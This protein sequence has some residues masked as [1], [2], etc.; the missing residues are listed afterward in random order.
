MTLLTICQQVAREVGVSVPTTI[1]SNN[2]P[3]AKKLL[4]CAQTEGRMLAKGIVYNAVGQ[5]K[6][7]H[8]WTAIRKEYT[9]NTANG[10]MA[11]NMPSDFERFVVDTWWN[12]TQTRRLT[13]ASA[14]RWQNL[15]SGLASS[16]GINQEF[17]KRGAQVLIY[18]TPTAT[19]TLVYEYVS[20]QWCESSGGTD[21]SSWAADSDVLLLDEDLFIAG[22]KWR[23]LRSVGESFADEKAEYYDLYTTKIGNDGG[24]ETAYMSYPESDRTPGIPDTGYGL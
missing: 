24:R 23:F 22:L 11:Y 1:V 4:A 15:K 9:F 12:R 6:G 5:I 3:N 17:I 10:T 20:N 16:S 18:P 8:D 21:Q 2:E 19:E 7:Q 14:N 13:L